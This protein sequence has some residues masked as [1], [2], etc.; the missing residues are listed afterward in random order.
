MQR[1]F[2]EFSIQ[3]WRG[4]WAPVG[5]PLSSSTAYSIDLGHETGRIPTE[6]RLIKTTMTVPRSVDSN[7]ATLGRNLI[8]RHTI[9]RISPP[10]PPRLATGSWFPFV[11]RRHAR[12]S[13]PRMIAVAGRMSSVQRAD[14]ASVPT[15][16][17]VLLMES[18]SGPERRHVSFREKRM[19]S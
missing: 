4:D 2:I 11:R 17:I 18:S 3:Q 19:T 16:S 8:Q 6:T 1:T 14:V 12:S 10:L 13:I 15:Y 7:N 5:R 9:R